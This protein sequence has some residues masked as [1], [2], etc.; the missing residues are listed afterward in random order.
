MKHK[1][2]MEKLQERLEH[3][4]AETKRLREA[5]RKLNNRLI[6]AELLIEKLSER[7]E[8][9]QDI[10]TLRKLTGRINGLRTQSVDF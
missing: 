7:Y 9:S 1:W 3:Q 2:T 8:V 10:E 5:N 6:K 4:R